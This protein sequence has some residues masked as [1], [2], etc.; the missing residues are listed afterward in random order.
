MNSQVVDT[1][2]F[3]LRHT[4]FNFKI[5][6]FNYMHLN[7]PES[8]AFSLCLRLFVQQLNLRMLKPRPYTSVACVFTFD[9]MFT[10]LFDKQRKSKN[11]VSNMYVCSWASGFYFSIFKFCSC[12]YSH[13]R[14][15]SLQLAQNLMRRR[16]QVNSIVYLLVGIYRI[17]LNDLKIQEVNGQFLQNYMGIA[18]SDYDL[19]YKF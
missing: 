16:R 7:L 14:N 12:T 15:M 1:F 18:S 19:L 17:L 11:C 5:Y 10:E 4:Q 6:T 8:N 2:N 9:E 13:R 3:V